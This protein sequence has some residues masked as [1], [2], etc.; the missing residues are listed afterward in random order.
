MTGRILAAAAPTIDVQE[1]DDSSAGINPTTLGPRRLF[2]RQWGT[3]DSGLA[4]N[5]LLDSKS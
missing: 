1:K 3:C 2:Q 5:G 4:I